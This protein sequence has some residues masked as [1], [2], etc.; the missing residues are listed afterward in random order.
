MVI[1][2]ISALLFPYVF[3]TVL[4]IFLAILAIIIGFGFFYEGIT[5]S[6]EN[7]LNRFLLTLS[8]ILGVC[9]GI[10]LLLALRILTFTIKDIIGIWAIITGIG[11]ISSVFISATGFD[12]IFKS[13]SGLALCLV[14]GV[15]LIAPALLT[16]YIL[17][18][19]LGFLAIVL[20][21]LTIIFASDKSKPKKEYNHLI[22]K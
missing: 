17:I 13:V 1:L 15:L 2:G 9:I 19:I 14:G 18:V 3:F 7:I 10:S 5:R 20:G 12:R 16:D 22:Y 21:I 8:G 11:Y 6:N 4:D